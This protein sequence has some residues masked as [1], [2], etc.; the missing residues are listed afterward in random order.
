MN[1]FFETF[2]HHFTRDYEIKANQQ[3]IFFNLCKSDHAEEQCANKHS[4]FAVSKKMQKCFNLGGDGK[5]PEFKLL[6][7]L[8]L[9][10][11]AS[12]LLQMK[13]N[14]RRAI[15]RTY[16]VVTGQLSARLVPSD[17]WRSKCTATLS[18]S[19]FVNHIVYKPQRNLI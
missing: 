6:G 14:Q 2:D 1:L 10:P 19:V 8:L 5:A 16:T 4:S 12:N 3:S 9:Y 17:L 18:R 15:R 13:M 11:S 7:W